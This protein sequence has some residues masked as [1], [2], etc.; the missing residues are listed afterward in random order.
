M[1]SAIVTG[2]NK[3]VGRGI[4]YSLLKAGI[5]VCICYNSSE[6]FALE[7]L[8]KANEIFE[9]GAFLHRC[10]VS[11]RGSVREMAE[12]TARRFGGIDILVNNAAMQPNHPIGKYDM[13]IFSSTWDINVGGYF[14]C[15]QECLPYLKK[16]VCPRVV[17]IA[18]VHAKRPSVF[19]VG[20]SMTK[21]AIKMFTREAAIELAKYGITANYITLGACKIEGKTIG[22]N[23]GS[24][25]VHVPDEARARTSFPLGRIPHPKD[26]GGLVVYL[27]SEESAMITGAGIR[28]DGASMLL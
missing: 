11:L 3:G 23:F 19:D 15:L 13:E 2:G 8:E 28:I 25:D 10:D 12:E 4:L 1:K 24:F 6:S 7:T 17:N 26:V 5:R 27:A 21:N 16:S 14:L 22:Q 18:S 9:G 20:Y